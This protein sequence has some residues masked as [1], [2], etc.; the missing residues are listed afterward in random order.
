MPGRSEALADVG[1]R[2]PPDRQANRQRRPDGALISSIVTST[3][4]PGRTLGWLATNCVI[5]DHGRKL[6][7]HAPAVRHPL[8]GVVRDV[9]EN[10]LDALGIDVDLEAARGLRQ[11]Q[12]DVVTEHPLQDRRHVA[13]R[14]RQV[15]RRDVADLLVAVGD[16]LPQEPGRARDVAE[17]QLALLPKPRVAFEARRATAGL[18]G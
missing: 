13:K 7:P 5:D 15:H 6:N 18:P 1:V 8:A 12:R 4:A 10:P 16:E 2:C 14:A 3:C 17:Q 11:Q 9:D